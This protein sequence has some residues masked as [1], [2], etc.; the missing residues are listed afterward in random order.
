MVLRVKIGAK[1]K[2]KKNTHPPLNEEKGPPI[3]NRTRWRYPPRFGVLNGS[4][5]AK[6]NALSSSLSLPLLSTQLSPRR[7]AVKACHYFTHPSSGRCFTTRLCLCL[8]LGAWD[9]CPT[10]TQTTRKK[11]AGFVRSRAPPVNYKSSNRSKLI[12]FV[13]LHFHISERAAQIKWRL[14]GFPN[15]R[16]RF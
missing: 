2:T 1:L 8:N 6:K 3:L 11:A 16:L 15:R 12:Y 4:E 14:L 13:L 9:L 10:R 5:K 7:G